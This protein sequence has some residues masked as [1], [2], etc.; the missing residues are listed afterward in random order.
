M[1]NKRITH[2]YYAEA[3][4]TTRMT[5]IAF[6]QIMRFQSADGH[7]LKLSFEFQVISRQIKKMILC[8]YVHGEVCLVLMARFYIF[9]VY[10]KICRYKCL[11]TIF[12]RLCTVFLCCINVVL[13][14]L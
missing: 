2:I 11:S 13:S 8:S 6:E 1:Y 9:A 10:K 12:Q 5:Q 14:S 7:S 3:K 4:S